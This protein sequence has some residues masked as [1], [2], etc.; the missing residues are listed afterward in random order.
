MGQIL[1]F[2]NVS[3]TV[4]ASGF[5]CEHCEGYDFLMLLK[6]ELARNVVS[7][8]NLDN[9]LKLI[10]KSDHLWGHGRRWS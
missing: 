9:E 6:C 10:A 7:A 5:G 2:R 1:P 3:I 4:P 8:E